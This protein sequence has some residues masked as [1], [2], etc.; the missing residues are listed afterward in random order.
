MALRNQTKVSSLLASLLM[1]NFLSFN[2]SKRPGSTKA[3]P[4]NL[5]PDKP[6]HPKI[7]ARGATSGGLT[8]AK[9]RYQMT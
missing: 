1:V 2:N 4:V 3:I 5:G 7:G 8:G 6:N 9:T